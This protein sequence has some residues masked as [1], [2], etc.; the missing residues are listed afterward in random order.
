MKK[1][2]ID[3]IDKH[4]TG[5][6]GLLKDL[7]LVQSGSA[8]KAGVDRVGR[9]IASKLA[10]LP[11]TVRVE[12]QESLG[13][14]LVASTERAGEQGNI[15]LIGHMDTIF[16]ADSPFAGWREDKKNVYGPGVIDMKGG[17]VAAIYALQGLFEAGLLQRMPL[18]IIFNSDEEIGSPAS[19]PII[20]RE[21]GKSAMAFVFECGGLNGEVVTGRKGR[22]VLKLLV[23]GRACHAAQTE[24]GKI[25]A[26]L[27]LAHSIIAL[28]TL[29]GKLPGLT[30]NVGR[31]AGG[32]APNVVPEEAWAL[33]DV[34]FKSAEGRSFF[35]SYLKELVQRS[36]V[37]GARK[38]VEIINERNVME[39]TEANS[40]LYRVVAGEA[41]GLGITVQEE[42]RVGCSDANIVARE[43]T[44][45]IDGLGPVGDY[46]H[47]DREFM[48]KESLFERTKLAALS[49]YQAWLKFQE[50]SL[51]NT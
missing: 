24:G 35:E 21:A 27:E 31:L 50:G 38:D 36:C 16:P 33:V 28:E 26:S 44:P 10:E 12:R 23:K 30:V 37:A 20:A 42:F 14:I 43:G 2:I 7:V 41:H 5:M 19:G 3:S 13:D 48:I 29:N 46:D 32:I 40:A 47:S 1:K 9:I 11:L 25:S 4:R 8:N 49:V 15:L 51:L 34:R 45:V 6:I 39:S 22:L 17:L 18:R